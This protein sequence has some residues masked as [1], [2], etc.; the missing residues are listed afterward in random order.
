MFYVDLMG[1]AATY[2]GTFETEIEAR[3]C[4]NRLCPMEGQT[5][6]LSQSFED[7]TEA[8]IEVCEGE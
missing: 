5:L 3:E 1:G 2:N 7:G 6:Y 4:F 8:D